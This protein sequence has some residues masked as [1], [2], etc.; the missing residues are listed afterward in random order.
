MKNLKKA[1]SALRK[2]IKCNVRGLHYFRFVEK[3]EDGSRLLRC[4]RCNR[5]RVTEA[6]KGKAA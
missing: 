2:W 3:R 1:W 4:V 5:E 6:R